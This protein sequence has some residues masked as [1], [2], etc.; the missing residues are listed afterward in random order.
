M[1]YFIISILWLGYCF[2]HSYL[3]SVRFSNYMKKLF[4]KYYAFY[5][6]FYNLFSLLLL[7]P[8]ID[9][10]NNIDKYIIIHY[11]YPYSIIRFV[12]LIG[13]LI[14]FFWAFFFD[15]D[16]L[17]FFGIR[18]IFNMQKKDMIKSQIRLKKNGLL[19][20]CRHPMY[21][22]LIIY[23]WCQTFR[24]ID[25]IINSI[26]TTYILIGTILEEKKLEVE[27][28]E[29]YFSYKSEVPMLIPF[30]KKIKKGN[31]CSYRN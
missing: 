5:R 10:S 19:G 6:V 21:F 27:F 12:F 1:D 2:L 20:L 28:G 14:L 22:A 25:I 16:S 30:T 9:Y 3:I 24:K 31:N 8:L 7:I 13:S 15:Y 26:L 29:D 23:L 4:Q 11:E 17:S 18:Q